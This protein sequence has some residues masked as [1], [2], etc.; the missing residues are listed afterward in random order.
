MSKQLM[1]DIG[2]FVEYVY[3]QQ[4][5]GDAWQKLMEDSRARAI[6]VPAQIH[7]RCL[8]QFMGDACSKF[9]GD[10]PTTNLHGR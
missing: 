1:E 4:F 10:A 6:N 2:E 9:M 8:L 5:M 3:L 7:G